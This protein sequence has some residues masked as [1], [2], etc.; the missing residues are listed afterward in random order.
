MLVVACGDP[1]APPVAHPNG[2]ISMSAGGGRTCA[3]TQDRDLYCWGQSFFGGVFQPARV[4]GIPGTSKAVS[5]SHGLTCVLTEAGST[6][7]WEQLGSPARVGGPAFSE[8]LA[9]A[10]S[11]CGLTG[12]GELY[13]WG[14][15]MYGGVGDGTTDDRTEPVRVAAGARF[16]QLSPGDSHAC[17]VTT[18]GEALCWGRN[19]WGVVGDGT[20]GNVRLQP[21]KVAGGH[22]F[23]S[24]HS[25]G[26]ITCALTEQGMAHCWGLAGLL[27][28]GTQETRP[29]PGP[30]AGSHSFRTLAAGNAHVCGLTPE[31]AVYCWGRNAEGQLG[32]G[33]REDALI[34]TRVHTTERFSDLA[35]GRHHTCGVTPAGVVFC[36][37]YNGDG[38]LGTGRVTMGWH[39]PVPVRW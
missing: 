21:T 9:A 27:G 12:S 30:V 23:R 29:V 10:F 15:N 2:V 33:T 11:A 34:P 3:I 32:T 38:Q 36:W 37:G 22:R 4:S 25:G 19:S 14:S 1:T 26:N 24:V 35:A 6:Y 16:R 39:T 5:V 8:V 17:A 13:C 7:C 28:D 31:G 18:G 20:L